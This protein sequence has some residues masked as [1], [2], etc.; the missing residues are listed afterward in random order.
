[1][2]N[3]N[4]AHRLLFSMVSLCLVNTVFP[5]ITQ[6]AAK[7]QVAVLSPTPGAE[8]VAKKPVITFSADETFLENGGIVLLDGNDVTQLVTK[9]DKNYSFQPVEPSHQ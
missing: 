1:M 7:Q 3:P 8:I 4:R 5:M 6:A 2:M 9:K